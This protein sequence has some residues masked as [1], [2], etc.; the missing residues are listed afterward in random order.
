M[1]EP[2]V[3]EYNEETM[4]S[5]NKNHREV[6]E[7]WQNPAKIS[8]FVNKSD[9][10]LNEIVNIP[11]YDGQLVPYTNW[12]YCLR[13]ILGSQRVFDVI[14]GSK[15]TYCKVYMRMNAEIVNRFINLNKDF[16]LPTSN[17]FNMGDLFYISPDLYN[18][19]EQLGVAGRE[20]KTTNFSLL[21]AVY[22]TGDINLMNINK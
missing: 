22:S 12:S 21:E 14:P 7:T 10:E 2:I 15:N 18:H 8:T 3:L 16:S 17:N 1:S 20:T 13:I 9:E 19:F 6:F 5:L 4:R 11:A